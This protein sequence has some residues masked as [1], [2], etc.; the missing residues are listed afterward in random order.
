[1]CEEL[2]GEI[3]PGNSFPAKNGGETR[4]T[5]G[6]GKAERED[7]CKLPQVQY[8][9]MSLLCTFSLSDIHDFVS[10]TYV[11]GQVMQCFNV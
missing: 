1:M 11:S 2:W 9:L 4:N 7:L 5:T 8:L 3:G 6:L 10:R